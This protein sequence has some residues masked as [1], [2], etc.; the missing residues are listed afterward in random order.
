ME[1]RIYSQLDGRPVQHE[2]H[3]SEGAAREALASF[4]S[5]Q[6]TAGRIVREV[7]TASALEYHIYE[8]KELIERHW[9][10]R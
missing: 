7:R 6:R 5:F 8:G 9:I 1:T 10:A 4:I 2:L 3:E